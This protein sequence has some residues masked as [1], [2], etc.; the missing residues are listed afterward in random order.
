MAVYDKEQQRVREELESLG[1][2]YL[3]DEIDESTLKNRMQEIIK[4]YYIALALY[5]AEDEEFSEQDLADLEFMID[6]SYGLVDDMVETFEEEPDLS[7]NYI[8]WRIGI[9]SFAHH[10]YSRYLVPD[11]IF[12]LMP[13]FP[14]VDC[15]GD[16][17][18]Q[19][20]LVVDTSDEGI[21]VEWVMGP[22]EHCAVCLAAATASPYTF[23]WHDLEEVM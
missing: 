8:L 7:E 11:E 16:G 9:F 20:D 19:C 4:A 18:C 6:A 5:G 23:S 1:R 13:V 2:S 3:E 12:A 22:T 15:L 10:V 21:T 14:G 17:A